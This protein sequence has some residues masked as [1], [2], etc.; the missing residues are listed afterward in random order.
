MRASLILSGKVP[1]ESFAVGQ[2]AKGLEKSRCPQPDS[3][4]T[5]RPVALC[6]LPD[7]EVA[8]AP[9]VPLPNGG[10]KNRI[11]EIRST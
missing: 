6:P 3:E 5:P 10:R 4:E 8:Y 1:Q 11:S 2:R 9:Q 7:S